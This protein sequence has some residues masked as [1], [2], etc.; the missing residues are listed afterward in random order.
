[1]P[2]S[3]QDCESCTDKSITLYAQT[4][5]VVKAANNKYL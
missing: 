1:M 4:I 2:A 5:A 3:D